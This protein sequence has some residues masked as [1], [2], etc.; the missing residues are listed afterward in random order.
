MEEDKKPKNKS[1]H[2]YQLIYDKR[3]K[4]IQW[5]KGSLFNCGTG[6]TGQLHAK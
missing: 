2:S 1:K 6:K 5:R 3:G 4:N